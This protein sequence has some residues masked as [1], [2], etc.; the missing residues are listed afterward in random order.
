MTHTIFSTLSLATV[1]LFAARASELFRDTLIRLRPC[2]SE[3]SR[4]RVWSYNAEAARQQSAWL[5]VRRQG[6]LLKN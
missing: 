6:A 2:D 4:G 5:P 3:Q 1:G